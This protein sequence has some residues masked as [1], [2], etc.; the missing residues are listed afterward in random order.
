MGR[1]LCPPHPRPLRT[2]LL[3]VSGV[4][5]SGEQRFRGDGSRCRV[6]ALPGPSCD[7]AAALVVAAQ[8]R[9]L[10]GGW[11]RPLLLWRV[12]VARHS[13]GAGCGSGCQGE[14][15]PRVPSFLSRS[16]GPSLGWPRQVFSQALLS[17]LKECHASVT[18][19]G[20]VDA[21]AEVSAHEA[22]RT[23][24]HRAFGRYLWQD[25]SG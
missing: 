14:P 17:P 9:Y 3:G 21:V 11:G 19:L 6:P 10:A 25:C 7:V 16:P 8:D 24:C 23:C 22:R 2:Q 5:S 15:G 18:A 1:S 4:Q 20:S 12:V 13:R